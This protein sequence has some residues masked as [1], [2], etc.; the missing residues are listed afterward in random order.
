MTYSQVKLIIFPKGGKIFHF[1]RAEGFAVSSVEQERGW[2]LVVNN[3]KKQSLGVI[4]G[5]TGRSTILSL[6][7]GNTMLELFVISKALLLPK[8]NLEFEDFV[9]LG[10]EKYESMDEMATILQT[11]SSL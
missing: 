9:L 5:D 4:A 11:Q 3:N 1:K 10:D 2:A 7:I 8:E 6:D